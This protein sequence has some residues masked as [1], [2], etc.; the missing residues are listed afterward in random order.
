WLAAVDLG[1]TGFHA[2]WALTGHR[3]NRSVAGLQVAVSTTTF[4]FG[5]NIIKAGEHD[6]LVIAGTAWSGLLI[7]HSIWILA[8]PAEE[9][10]A[11]PLN[12]SVGNG[13]VALDFQGS[14]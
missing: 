2:G 7:A 5:A 14:F 1:F 13:T 8:H 12:V 6:P 3:P 9:P 4:I 11:L 10:K